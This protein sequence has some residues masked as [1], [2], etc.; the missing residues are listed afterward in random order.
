MGWFTSWYGWLGLALVLGLVG[1]REWKLHD[2]SRDEAHRISCEQLGRNGPGGN[3]HVEMTDALLC[4]DALVYKEKFGRWMSVLVPAVPTDSVYARSVEQF[5]R[6][7]GRDSGAKPPP[8]RDF[9]V[10]VRLTNVKSHEDA[11][12]VA[13]ERVFVGHVVNES[14]PLDTTED[15]L[16]EATFPHADLDDLVLLEIG[17]APPTASR[18][19]LY[20]GGSLVC[21]VIGLLFLRRR[22]RQWVVKRAAKS[23]AKEAKRA[24]AA[25]AADNP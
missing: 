15:G 11:R 2:T 5:R 14:D 10:L 1:V 17:R 20:F 4:A 21:G 13:N 12:R 22:W 8:P 18:I 7:Q 6:D 19:A 9:H 3:A 16:L 23:A 25:E 24:A